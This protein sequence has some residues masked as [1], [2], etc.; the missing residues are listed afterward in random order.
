MPQKEVYTEILKLDPLNIDGLNSLA[1]CIKA[2]TTTGVFDL[3]LPLYKKALS[4]DPEDFETNF[5][6]GVLYYE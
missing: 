6:I 1:Q 4:V 3:V 5:N 2:S